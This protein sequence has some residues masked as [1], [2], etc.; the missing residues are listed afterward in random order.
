MVRLEG[1]DDS[2]NAPIKDYPSK[3]GFMP[4]PGADPE[5]RIAILSAE[6]QTSHMGRY[7]NQVEGTER[8]QQMINKLVAVPAKG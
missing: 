2:K 5:A 3:F 1:A 6:I 7:G 8:Y 4:G